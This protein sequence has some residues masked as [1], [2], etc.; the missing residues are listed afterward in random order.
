[1]ARSVFTPPAQLRNSINHHCG[2][3]LRLLTLIFPGGCSL[4]SCFD[5]LIHERYPQEGGKILLEGAKRFRRKLSRL[6][7]MPGATCPQSGGK[8]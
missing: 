8:P 2:I 1:M 6:E 4:S 7:G 5:P 3:A